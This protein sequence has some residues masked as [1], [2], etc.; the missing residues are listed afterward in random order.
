[1]SALTISISLLGCW[2]NIV[3]YC[4]CDGLLNSL[5]SSLLCVCVNSFRTAVH[6]AAYSDRCEALQLLLSS[7]GD[8]GSVDSLGRTP[9]MYAA[10]VGRCTAI[11][12]QSIK[13]LIIYK[14]LQS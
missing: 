1:M 13:I 2:L 6:A 14:Y 3:S 4:V 10:M 8:I 5:R 11:G 7:S 12:N 9:L